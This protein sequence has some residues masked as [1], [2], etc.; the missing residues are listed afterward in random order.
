MPRPLIVPPD[1]VKGG[2]TPCL[3]GRWDQLEGA[4]RAAGFTYDTSIPGPGMAWP[5]R[6]HG[7]W[8]FHMPTVHSP[9]LGNVLAMD[10]NFWFKFNRARDQPER[11]PELRQDVLDTYR[12]MYQVAFDG[13]RAPVLVANHFN[14]WTGDAFNPAAADFMTETCAK[15]ETICATYSD[16][17]AWM[18]IQDP[19]VLSFLQA[20]PPLN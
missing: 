1:A 8:E 17:I 12:H 18:S 5:R 10:Y 3:E 16:V 15:P 9:S 20:L 7:V 11:G 14:R 6:E 19:A 2:R 4:W 13:S